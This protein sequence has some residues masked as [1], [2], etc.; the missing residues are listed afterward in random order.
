VAAVPDLARALS[1]D[2]A[3]VVRRNAA[4]ALGHIGRDSEEVIPALENAI[5]A[6]L[7]ALKPSEPREVR[8]F[9]A[10]AISEIAYP[11]NKKAIPALLDLLK[12][13]TD[14]MVRKN[15]VSA[16]LWYGRRIPPAREL[17]RLGADKVLAQ[18]LEE[19]NPKTAIVRYY[20]ARLLAASM[21]EEAPDRTADV[22]LE[23]LRNKDLVEYKGR[24]AR[25]EGGATEVSG[26]RAEVN[27][28]TGNDARYQAAEGLGWLGAKVAARK[29]V[30]Q[31]LTAAT[32][33]PGAKLREVAAEALKQIRGR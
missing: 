21:R 5:P 4:L 24:D 29:D 22:L 13:D 26:G 31:A 7:R 23:M 6:L 15:C 30:V 9:V 8:Q 17:T 11:A 32:R 20:A 16:L 19:T 10:E 33:D 14:P 27:E 1:S 12:S 25:I 28:N 18:V 3:V 2:R